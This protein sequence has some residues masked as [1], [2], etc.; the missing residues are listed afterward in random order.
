M[1]GDKALI[2][3]I[4]LKHAY[5]T[6]AEC[7]DYFLGQFALGRTHNPKDA[8]TRSRDMFLRGDYPVMVVT[9]APSRSAAT[10][11]GPTPGTARIRT[12][13]SSRSPTRTCR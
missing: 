8:F 1:P 12:A 10:W 11:S 6:G 4:N 2:E 7:I 3:E 13:G 9:M 5:Q